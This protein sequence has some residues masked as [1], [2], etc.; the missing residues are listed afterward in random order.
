MNS[1]PAPV[2]WLLVG[3]LSYRSPA[4]LARRAALR[5][6]CNSSAGLAEVRFV[7]GEP[8]AD[9]HLPD[10]LVFDVPRNDRVL[11]TYLLTN[12]WFRYALATGASYVARADDDSAFDAG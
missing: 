6:V 12:R 2:P 11:G 8:D 10:T 1:T 4:A 9:A 7:L 3:V 5:T